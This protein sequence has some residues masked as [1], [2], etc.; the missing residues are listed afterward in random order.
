MSGNLLV[1]HSHFHCSY[2]PSLLLFS[3]L[4]W[5][6]NN[7]LLW[8]FVALAVVCAGT[9]FSF[10][11]YYLPPLLRTPN[12]PSPCSN[13]GIYCGGSTCQDD[14][15]ISS[16]PSWKKERYYLPKRPIV[17]RIHFTSACFETPLLFTWLLLA[18]SHLSKLV[19][20][21]WPVR[22]SGNTTRPR[23]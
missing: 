2:H 18:K 22:N 21:T 1:C 11:F 14:N 5:P 8:L 10:C 15:G 19:I 23:G 4:L 16:C 9:S 3:N 13:G 6:S 7:W 12:L 20:C 17:L